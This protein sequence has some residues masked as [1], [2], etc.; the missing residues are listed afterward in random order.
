MPHRALLRR[1]YGISL[2]VGSLVGALLWAFA[3]G[4][5][6]VGFQIGL[7]TAL[8]SLR[9]LE[10][11]VPAVL[12]PTGRWAGRK[13]RLYVLVLAKYLGFGVLLFWVART[14][15]ARVEAFAA[16]FIVPQ[17]AI[18]LVAVAQFFRELHGDAE[19]RPEMTDKLARK[20]A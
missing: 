9:S 2:V 8:G 11:V 13:R 15:V 1:V 3:S 5:V 6:L 17:A 14:P 4:P 20:E 19:K 12:R 18:F 16:G 7:V 10:V